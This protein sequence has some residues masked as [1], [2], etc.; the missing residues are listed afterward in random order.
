MRRLVERVVA[1]DFSLR[2]LLVL[3]RRMPKE[4]QKKTLLIQ[5]DVCTPPLARRFFTK[6]VSFQV[7]EHLPSATA[8]RQ[9][10]SAV[11][12]LL[13]PG[14]SFT[15]TVYHWSKA[16]QRDA[17]RG[18]GDNTHK[19]GFHDSNIYYYNFEEP[20]LRA[21]LHAAGMQVEW[22]KGL[23]IALRGSRLL[24]PLLLPM[25]RLLSSTRWGIRRSHLLLARARPIS[26]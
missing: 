17:A 14:G 19:E 10:A 11:A 8:R 13:A 26:Q 15:C 7:F 20:E 24:G 1:L 5:A 3:R 21:M 25:N 2:S 18:V 22:T 4:L 9:A 23:V 16:K 6:A 12:E